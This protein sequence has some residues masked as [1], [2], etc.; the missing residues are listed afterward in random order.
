MELTASPAPCSSLLLPSVTLLFLF[1][2]VIML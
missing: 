2:H 1:I